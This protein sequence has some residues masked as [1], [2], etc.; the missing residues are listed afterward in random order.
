MSQPADPQ[1]DLSADP[2]L[3]ALV[4]SLRATARNRVFA[5][6]YAGC[7]YW[8][9]SAGPPRLR[10]SVLLQAA[11]AG[12]FRLPLLRPPHMPGGAS[13]LAAEAAA[14]RELAAAGFPVPAVIACAPEWLVLG[15]ASEGLEPQLNAAADDE[16]RWALIA[17]AA[18][19]LGR[20]HAAGHWH[21][22]AHFR[23]FCRSPATGE[24]GLLDFEDHD[25]PGM[26]TA[27]RQARDLLLFIYSLARYDP[28]PDAPRLTALATHLLAAAA[29]DSRRALRRLRRRMGWLLGRARRVRRG[30]G[31]DVRQAQETPA[32]L[33]APQAACPP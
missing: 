23:N 8:V 29:P 22:G 10:S 17:G 25:L 32:V 15:D 4:R 27:E 31:R 24:I 30:G 33:T 9:K 21:G 14:I 1:P 6:T 2:D 20:L 13:G 3:A 12:L 16:T 19:L 5:L 11:L 18:A 7:K 26:M 28:A